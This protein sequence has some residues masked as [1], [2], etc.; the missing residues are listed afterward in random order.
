MILPHFST[1]VSAC[2]EATCIWAKA[3]AH[4]ASRS[5]LPARHSAERPQRRTTG[6]HMPRLLVGPIADVGHDHTAAFEL[7]SHARVDTALAPP[8]LLH[9]RKYIVAHGSH[10]RITSMQCIDME[11]VSDATS[12][13]AS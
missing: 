13:P 10:S 4:S 8:R 7:A 11:V 6:Q 12:S 1:A 3:K 2:Y 9:S 5:L